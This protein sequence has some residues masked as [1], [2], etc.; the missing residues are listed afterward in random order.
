MNTRIEYDRMWENNR[1]L[2]LNYLEEKKFARVIDV[3]ASMN[4]WAFDYMSHYVDI[5]PIENES[6]KIGFIG[7]ICEYDVWKPIL[8]DVEKNGKFDFAI[9][10]HTLEDIRNP[11]FVVN[12]IS[13]I[14]KKGFAA[15]PS[16]YYEF[17][18]H[19][20]PYRG[21]QHHRWIFNRENNEIVVYPKLPF[22]DYIEAFDQLAIS[23]RLD[24]KGELQWFWQHE[25]KIRF[26]N[27]D[28]LGPSPAHVYK[29]YEGLLNE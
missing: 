2:A 19:E 28:Y 29:Y 14:A 8:K 25:M 9:C 24:E 7:N 18:R 6:D 21:W 20:G 13:S 22:V 1:A 5:N 17:T 26:I 12:M 4:S 11:G 10:T 15:V 27:N 23:N 16:K 3:G